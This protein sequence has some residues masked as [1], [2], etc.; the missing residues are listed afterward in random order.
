MAEDT[1]MVSNDCYNLK[2][3]V[4][5]LGGIPSYQKA[6]FIA[7]LNRNCYI[8]AM[9]FLMTV[10]LRSNPRMKFAFVDNIDAWSKPKLLDAQDYLSKSW[11]FPILHIAEK[12]GFSSHI[13]PGTKDIWDTT[14]TNDLTMKK[15][16]MKDGTHPNTDTTGESIRNIG[17][18]VAMQLYCNSIVG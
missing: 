11:C 18:L 1:Y 6:Q 12:C 7:S 3:F 14:A 2:R 5:D 13:I 10:I 17:T 9:N 8:G 16:Y 15:I 4:G